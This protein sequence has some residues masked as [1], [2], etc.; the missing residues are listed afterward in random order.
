MTDHAH[1]LVHVAIQRHFDQSQNTTI[2]CI[3]Q[4]LVLLNDLHLGQFAIQRTR[5]QTRASY[6]QGI[7][8][9]CPNFKVRIGEEN[10]CAFFVRILGFVVL[11]GSASGRIVFL[12]LFDALS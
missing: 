6:K 10:E 7:R 11:N 2:C 9:Q 1:T 5:T 4:V 8:I 3:R 12:D